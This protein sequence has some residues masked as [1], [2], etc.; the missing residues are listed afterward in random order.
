VAEGPLTLPVARADTGIVR[1]G[2]KVP[3]RITVED[4]DDRPERMVSDPDHYFAEAR[5]RAEQEVRRQAA[6]LFP[7][8]RSQS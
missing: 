7:R 5:E 3:I 1:K 6:W 2:A 8:R 4:H